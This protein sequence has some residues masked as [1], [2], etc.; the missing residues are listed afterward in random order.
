LTVAHAEHL[1]ALDGDAEVMRHLTGRARSRDEVLDEWL[2]VLTRETGRGDVLGYWAGFVRDEW[3]QTPSQGADFLAFGT[4]RND[5][6]AGWW[7]LNPAPDA[8]RQAELGY[9]LRRDHWGRGLASEGAAAL[10]EHGFTAAGIERIWAQTMAVNTASRRVMERVG[11][12]FSRTWVGKWNEP[13]PGWEQGEVEYEI[14]LADW[15]GGLDI[16]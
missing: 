13:L 1:V 10:V 8:E 6:F 15:S 11:M 16:R 4:N 7:A 12:R 14:T 5:R 9:R 3:S 2:P